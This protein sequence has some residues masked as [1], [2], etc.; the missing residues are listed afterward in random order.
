[1]FLFTSGVENDSIDEAVG[2]DNEFEHNYNQH[3]CGLCP[4]PLPLDK[5]PMSIAVRTLP[6]PVV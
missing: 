1:M 2:D 6:K 4:S 3:C 5:K